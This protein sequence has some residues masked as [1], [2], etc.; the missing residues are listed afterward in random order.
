[1]S[2]Q[3]TILFRALSPKGPLPSPS[4]STPKYAAGTF[5]SVFR[6]N[7][8]TPLGENTRFFIY[9]MFY[10]CFLGDGGIVIFFW[11]VNNVCWVMRLSLGFCLFWLIAENE[12]LEVQISFSMEKVKAFFIFMVL[13]SFLFSFPLVSQQPNWGQNFTDFVCFFFLGL[14][15]GFW[16]SKML[17][18]PDSFEIYVL[19]CI[20]QLFLQWR[21]L[22]SLDF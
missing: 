21:Y 22:F 6:I 19:H 7:H 15:S 10:I 11:C 2:S 9:Y 1:M 3:S 5:L 4:S 12:I 13:W 16:K 20:S 17:R 8:P 18:M 14:C